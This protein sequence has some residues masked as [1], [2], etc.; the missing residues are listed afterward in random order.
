MILCFDSVLE[1]HCIVKHTIPLSK[2]MDSSL[3]VMNIIS[4][5]CSRDIYI[6]KSECKHWKIDK[7]ILN[8]SQSYH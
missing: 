2:N 7:R 5:G 6:V 1:E 8:A 4:T 3:N